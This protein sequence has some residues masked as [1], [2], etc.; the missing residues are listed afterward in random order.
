MAQNKDR[1]TEK[2]LGMRSPEG[3]REAENQ[4]ETERGHK[5]LERQRSTERGTNF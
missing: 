2:E 1:W 4:E 5:G 3:R